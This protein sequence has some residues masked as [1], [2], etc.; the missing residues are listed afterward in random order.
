MCRRYRLRSGVARTGALMKISL[1][2]RQ[3][4]VKVDA[5]RLQKIARLALAKILG[6]WLDPDASLAALREVEVTLVDDASISEIHRQFFN[7]PTPTDVISFDHGEILI[8]AETALAN[9]A[10]YRTTPE[11]EIALYIIH[12]L[13][14]INGYGDKSPAAAAKM[15]RT[16]K[17]ILASCLRQV[18][19]DADPR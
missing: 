4:A 14:H 19:G 16:Q 11:N 17:K 18:R 12:G 13:L 3:R 15:S 10:R 7:D 8:S 1:H 9:S 6:E 5:R 2:N